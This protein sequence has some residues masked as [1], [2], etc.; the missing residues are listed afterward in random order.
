MT[1]DYNMLYQQLG[2]LLETPANLSTFKD[3]VQPATLQWLGRSHALVKA[4]N[5]GAGYDAITFTT[6][7]DN[8][9]TAA[10]ESVGHTSFSAPLPCIGPLRIAF[11][12]R[13]GGIFYSCGQQ[14]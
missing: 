4:V 9:R 8:M 2:R 13:V 12:G 3:C 11:A 1:T 14:L 10:W 6:A 7:M 5:V